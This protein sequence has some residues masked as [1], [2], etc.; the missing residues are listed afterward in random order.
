MAER[1]IIMAEGLRKSYRSVRAL[2]GVDLE[3]SEGT[4]LGLLGPNGAGKTTTVRILTTLLAPDGGRAEVAGFDVVSE[5]GKV[6]SAIGLAGQFMAVDANLTGREN[7]VMVGRLYQLSRREASEQADEILA[8]FDLVGAG[9]RRVKTY[10]GG[11]QR[12]LD[13][14]A[15]LIGRPRVL[16]LDEPTAGLDPRSRIGLWEVI[17]ELVAAGTTILLTTQYLEEVDRLA[18]SIM[19]IDNG[20][21]IARGTAASL[22]ATVGGEILE[23]RLTEPGE[24]AVAASVVATVCGAPVDVDERRARVTARLPQAAPLMAEVVRRLD[25]VNVGIAGLTVHE[26]TLDTVFMALTGT[27]DEGRVADAAPEPSGN[28]QTGKAETP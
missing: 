17:A 20:S 28:G 21:V 4:V 2:R 11:M 3:V 12:R 7:L 26:P 19:V 9:D 22:K 14:G 15:S 25:E 16:F 23:V 13:L 24:L 27:S 8:R 10:S 6:R 5:P 1:P 18:D